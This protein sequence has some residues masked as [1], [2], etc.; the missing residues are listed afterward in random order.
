MNE[1]T[2]QILNINNA[3]SN[4]IEK[5]TPSE[6]GFWSSNILKYLRDFVEHISLKEYGNGNDICNTYDNIKL[7]IDYIKT[8]GDLKFLRNFH[9]L[10]QK[11]VSHYVSSPENSE[12]LMLKYYEYLLK[13][14]HHLRNEYNLEVLNNIDNFPINTDSTLEEYYA[15]IAE[16]INNPINVE[17]DYYNDRYYIKK[18]K[19]FFVSQEIYYEITFTIANN[20]V[21]KFDRV[22]AF[23]KLNILKNYAVKLSVIHGSIDIL[24]KKMP[25]RIIDNWGVSIRPCEINNFIGIVDASIKTQTTNQESKNLMAVLTET[26]LN[27]TEIVEMSNDCYQKIKNKVTVNTKSTHFFNIL[28]KSRELVIAK[29]PGSNVIKYLLYNLNNNNIKLQKSNEK[30]SGLSYLYLDW[31]C[32]PF[33]EMPFNTSLRGHNP[34][35]SDVFKCISSENREHELLARFIKNNTENKGKLYTSID[36]IYNFESIENLIDNYN[37]K[38]YHKHKPLR[39]IKKCNNHLYIENYE[40]QTINIIEEIKKLSEKSINNYYN[41][42]NSWLDSSEYNIDCDEKRNI[43][44][45]IFENSKVALIY[46]AAG[47][48]KSTL[49][50]H[51]S[52]FFSDRK[53]L[54][55]ANTNPAVDNLKRRV[56]APNCTFYTIA[57]FVNSD[58]DNEYDLLII[59]ECSTVS[60]ADMVKVLDRANFKLLVLVGDTFQIESITFGNWFNII[61]SF[62]PNNSVFKLLNP[63]RT[64]NDNLLKL[65][66]VVRNIDDNILEYIITNNYSVTLNASIF[67]KL[68]ND[69]IILCL[70]YDGL[71]GINNLNKFL[72]GSNHK[73]AVRWGIQTYKIKDPILFNETNRFAP[74]IYN[75]LKGK[76]ND[77][78]EL[79]EQIQFDIEI[80]NTINE[81]DAETYNFELLGNAENGNSIISFC[82]NKHGSTDEDSDSSD[83]IVPFQVAY[84]ISIHKAQGLEYNSVKMVIAN[85][86]EEMITHNIF[87]TAITRSKDKL[88]IYWT[89]ETENKILNNL[90]RL[91]SQKDRLFLLDKINNK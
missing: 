72:Q 56:K 70:N 65:W 71:Y 86:T 8:R 57:K 47:T 4:N 46:G 29:K 43:L 13:I 42:V 31:G 21:S 27:L 14:K 38:L 76:I 48:G 25:I 44:K 82:V 41:S 66:E 88:K 17:R 64:T 23:T 59:D 58:V 49:I 37:N 75:N 69:E 22:I 60:N 63:Y 79:G 77:I 51:I 54:Y 20:K 9:N 3:I 11:S 34:K 89:P 50:N 84:A 67:E 6:R 5:I 33:D 16:K 19:P 30:C 1:I 52:N 78:Q 68:E 15:K 90:E 74:L 91:D 39:E 87:Y 24:G 12:R 62:I 73:K 45:Q 26:S 36:D 7:S 53:K 55:L 28:D 61:E 81:F 40:K 85:E 18:I 83:T 10:L 32:K 2:N 35:I 80:D